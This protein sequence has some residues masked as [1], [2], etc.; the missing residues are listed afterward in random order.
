MMSYSKYRR[1]NA[2]VSGIAATLG[3]GGGTR[4]GIWGHRQLD[5]QDIWNHSETENTCMCGDKIGDI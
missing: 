2:L 4:L 5:E 1:Y 3:L